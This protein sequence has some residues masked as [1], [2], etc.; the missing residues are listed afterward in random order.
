[1]DDYCKEQQIKSGQKPRM[2][3]EEIAEAIAMLEANCKKK[4]GR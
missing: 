1:L 4:N 3:D 2:N